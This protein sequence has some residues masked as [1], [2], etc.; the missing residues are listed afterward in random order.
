MSEYGLTTMK[1]TKNGQTLKTKDKE[2][3][4]F[5]I[6]RWSLRTANE[7]SYLCFLS[8]F[9]LGAGEIFYDPIISIA[10]VENFP[11]LEDQIIIAIRLS[12]QKRLVINLCRNFWRSRIRIE[13]EEEDDR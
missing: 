10:K 8:E 9:D 6:F 2:P 11:L 13:S 5:K 12:S 1:L 7:I 4:T 3:V